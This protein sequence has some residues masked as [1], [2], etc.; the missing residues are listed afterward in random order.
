MSDSFWNQ[1]AKP[2]IGL[3]PM[4]GVTDFPFRHITKKYGNPAVIYT[5][6]TSV[7]GVCHGAKQLLKDFLY[8]EIQRPV[9]AQV[10]GTTPKFFRQTAVILCE[11]GFDGIDINMGCPAKN[12]AHSGAGAA[13]IKT[14]DLAQEIIQET[15]AGIQDWVNGKT[16]K[17]CPDITEE[18][19]QEVQER[20]RLLPSQYQERRALPVSVKTRIGYDTPTVEE[21]ISYLL[22]MEPAAIA[23]HGRTL[24]QQYGGSASWEEIGKAA[25]LIHQTNT[26]VLGNGD[27]KSLADAQEKIATYHTDGALL[28]RITMGNPTIF[29]N[30]SDEVSNTNIFAI[31]LEHAQLYEQTFQQEEKYTFMPMRK[32]LGWYIHDIPNAGQIR[33]EIYR[34]NSSA[35][36]LQILE[37]YELI[38]K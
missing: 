16:S 13:L 9:L 18:I 36:F 35:E 2:I 26:L 4:D 3:S 31:A 25:D 6:F 10:Y 37:K 15:R 21:W 19:A 22:E 28:G 20:H 34:S 14:P 27:L 23:I 30:V 24:K 33:Q 5:E 7:E 17:D 29:Q 8:D 11:M 1:L 38:A 12:V 32:H